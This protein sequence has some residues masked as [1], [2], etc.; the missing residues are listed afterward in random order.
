MKAFIKVVAGI[1]TG[2]GCLATVLGVVG[3]FAGHSDSDF[4]ISA[5][6]IGSGLVCVLFAGIAWMLVEIA[7]TLS[8]MLI[9]QYKQADASNCRTTK[10][11]ASA[12]ETKE[13]GI[14]FQPPSERHW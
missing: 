3:L 4:Q 7:G 14:A 2:V 13:Q 11:T 9:E 5:V 8:E 10:G 12:L 6:V 1:A